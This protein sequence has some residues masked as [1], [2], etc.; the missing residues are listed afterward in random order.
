MSSNTDDTS[1]ITP[2]SE[3]PER[4]LSPEL[5][6]TKTSPKSVKV[7]PMNPLV[8]GSVRG[9]RRKRSSASGRGSSSKSKSAMPVP[10]LSLKQDRTLQAIK[11]LGIKPEE[12]DAA[13][14]VTPL[15]KLADGGLKAVLG[16]MRFSGQNDT[17]QKFL[18]K[19]DSIPSG[20]RERLPWEAILIAA[21]VDFDT[22]VGAATFAI[23]NV[24]ANKSKIIMA[25]SHPKITEARVRYA[26][27]PSGEKDRNA[28]DIMVGAMPS[29]KG[30]TFIGKAIYGGAS[31]TAAG[32]RDEDDTPQDATY[33]DDGN[34]DN[35]FPPSDAMQERLIP[36]R[37]KLLE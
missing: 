30:V 29:P 20:D 23:A 31:Q 14:G 2:N 5:K 3:S 7:L 16:A 28:L 37:Q 22:F 24:S 4:L 8:N 1:V 27:L 17:L 6:R 26:L 36:I 13:P 35:L 34:L 15:L 32:D 19:Y 18:H 21:E 9:S 10:K 11:R 33:V 12:V 25:S